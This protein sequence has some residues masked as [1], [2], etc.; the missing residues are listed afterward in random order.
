MEIVK[1]ILLTKKNFKNSYV[2]IGTF[3]GIHMGHRVIIEKAVKEA[4][5][6]K[7]SSVVFTFLNHPMEIIDN[8]KTPKLINS[9]DEKIQILESLEVDYL[10]LQ[11]FTEKF[12]KL[13]PENFINKILKKI[14]NTKK[15]Y[16]GFN[17][18]FGKNGE[19]RLD[20]LKELG[21]RYKIEIDIVEPIKKDNE[22]ISSTYIRKLL[23]NGE[24]QKANSCLKQPFVIIEEVIHGRKLGRLLGFPTANLKI[25]KKI[26]PPFGIYGCRVKIENENCYRDAVVNIGENPTLKPNEKS[27]EVHILDF[28]NDIYG[29]KI[30]VYLLKFLRAEQKFETIDEL[31]K[32]IK[33]DVLTW[34]HRDRGMKNGDGI[35]N[36]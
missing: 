26:Y 3:D 22:I 8:K 30:H 12:S 20:S 2:A 25:C 17:F 16:V 36:R 9:L 35:K 32:M 24:L 33:N 7:G 34:K 27:I 18:S 28:D 21:T 29:K 4:K 11:P 15:I 5:M 1:D 23:T 31:K 19:G 13:S 6:N 14:L 10:I